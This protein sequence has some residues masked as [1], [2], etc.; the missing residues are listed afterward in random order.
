[1]KA[2]FMP[3]RQS[4]AVFGAGLKSSVSKLSVG[5]VQISGVGATTTLV[6]MPFQG[7]IQQPKSLLHLVPVETIKTTKSDKRCRIGT[8]SA[9]L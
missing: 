6:G 9:E 3:R 4:M 2:Y 8:A 7:R 5:V 1:M